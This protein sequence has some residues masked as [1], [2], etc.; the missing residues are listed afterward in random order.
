MSSFIKET[1]V[2]DIFTY[3]I[4]NIKKNK[5][6]FDNLCWFCNQRCSTFV[7]ICVNCQDEKFKFNKKN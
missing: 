5:N 7:K 3:K 2:R 4:V 1:Y 6:I